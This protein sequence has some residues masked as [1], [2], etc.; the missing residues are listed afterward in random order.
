[1][2]AKKVFL[3]SVAMFFAGIL[4]SQERIRSGQLPLVIESGVELKN[5][6]SGGFNS[7]QFNQIDLNYD[8]VM[9][10]LVFDRNGDRTLLFLNDGSGNYSFTR[11]YSNQLP[12]GLN[13]WVVTRDFNCD[14]KMDIVTNS[15]SGFILFFNTG[16]AQN[17]MNWEQLLTTNFN[18]LVM[19][20][21]D[22][23]NDPFT[24]PVYSLSIDL[25]SFTDHDD[26]GDIDLFTFTELSST[27]YYYKNMA[28]EN[29]NCA[30]PDYKC[31]NRCY[32]YFSESIESFD[33][34]FGEQS[35]C[36]FNVVDPRIARPNE[37]EESNRLHAG[38][39][40]LQID[41]DNNGIDDLILS[42]VTESN[43]AAL[44]IVN[45]SENRDSVALAQMDFP[46][47]NGSQVAVDMSIFPAGYYL[48][49]NNDGVKELVISPNTSSES[50]DRFSVWR[51][52]NDGQNDLPNFSLSTTNFLQSEMIDVGTNASPCF[53]DIN[54]DGLI[55]LI[56]ANRRHNTPDNSFSSKLRY[57]KNIGTPEVPKYELVA[58][59]YLN[60][61]SY[62]WRSVY[63]TFG[64]IDGDGDRE[65]FLGDLDGVIHVFYN[66]NN[67]V[68]ESQFELSQALLTNSSNQTIDVGQSSTPQLIDYDEDGLLD[69]MIGEKNG[70]INYYRNNGS[71]EIPSFELIEDSVGDVVATSFLGVD[72]FSV[73]H[74]FKNTSNQWEL[75]VGSET[76]QLNHY[77]APIALIFESFNFLA[78]DYFGE[79]E[80]TRTAPAMRDV[81]N[82]GITEVV[83]GQ[84]GGG[85][86]M[87]LSEALTTQVD[88][89][90]QSIWNIYPNPV[91]RSS[92][93]QINRKTNGPAL[94]QV[95]DIIGKLERTERVVGENIMLRAPQQ[96]GSY[97]IFVDGRSTI[98]LVR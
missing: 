56:V 9:D 39:T 90:D 91:L 98:L 8:G 36:Q 24:A 13:N 20:N 18:N 85:M 42:D 80:G 28:V 52:E 51:F 55:D 12:G 62:Q 45:S 78:D 3:F 65:L 96:P 40:L 50:E 4:F 25:P 27:V 37:S 33:M 43:M 15:Q 30:V 83:V 67:G 16:N 87:Y 6:W 26:D 88:N 11:N 89:S 69:L 10:L 23:S 57:Y 49:L 63:P 22:F 74:F 17:G 34:F 86:A 44:L 94:V 29:G 68:G 95:Y 84:V 54:Y 21:Y 82:D 53:E 64:D 92:M 35:D 97:L 93:F 1:M 77:E 66:I 73:P 48:D 79:V 7:P 71:T 76:G 38:G 70:N 47:D 5:P 59:N 61:P 19:A 41:L 72:G 31:V 81:T 46:M 2:G 58:D 14:G 60:I 75:I 32:G